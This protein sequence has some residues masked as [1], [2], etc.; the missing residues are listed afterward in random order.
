MYINIFEPY[1]S[2]T[3]FKK[4]EVKRYSLLFFIFLLIFR[5]DTEAELQLVKK[6]AEGN[7]AFRAVLCDHWAQGG[8]GAL[9]LADAVIDACEKPNKFKFLY[10]ENISIQEKIQ[11]I[12]TEMY[13]AGKIEYTN[14]VLEKIKDYN[15][16]VC[17]GF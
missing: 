11:T 17:Y 4:I 9:D 5:N 10:P 14:D 6:Y 13:G 12:A 8:T 7:G 16:K 15:Q 2:F 1:I 3:Y